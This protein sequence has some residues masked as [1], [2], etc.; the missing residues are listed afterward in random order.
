MSLRVVSI[1]IVVAAGSAT[2]AYASSPES[3]ANLDTRVNRA[4]IAMSG[5]ARPQVLG[6]KISFSDAIGVEV[7]MIRGYDN[8]N[9]FHRKLCA[10]NR[11][12]SRTEV[13]DAGSW[14]GATVRP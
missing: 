8:R 6:Q 10:F 1:A 7:R 13:E 14:F 2:L 11:R 9:R 5:L 3:W 12:T 4:C